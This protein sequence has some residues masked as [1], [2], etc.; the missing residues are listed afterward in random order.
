MLLAPAWALK[1][2]AGCSR[3]P[4]G[5]A[6]LLVVLGLGILAARR[7]GGIVLRRIPGRLPDRL[8]RARRYPVER[9]LMA[10]R[11]A[12]RRALGPAPPLPPFGVL[13][14]GGDGERGW[15]WSGFTGLRAA[16]FISLNPLS[17]QSA[18]L[19]PLPS[20]IRGRFAAA[21]AQ[22]R[23]PALV[24]RPARSIRHQRPHR[25]LS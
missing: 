13:V 6:L 17:R 19:S 8:D 25:D 3:A 18:P 10:E 1:H 12:V 14:T 2:F 16:V 11:D 4:F 7:T 24:A 15:G 22:A 9:G 21:S 5:V 20:P 23:H